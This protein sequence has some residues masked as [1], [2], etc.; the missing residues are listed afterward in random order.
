MDSLTNIFNNA[1]RGG[2]AA[3]VAVVLNTAAATSP[4]SAPPTQ[5]AISVATSPI[6]DH[7]RTTKDLVRESESAFSDLDFRTRIRDAVI[8]DIDKVRKDSG[9]S[10]LAQAAADK[11]TAPTQ[12]PDFISPDDIMRAVRNMSRGNGGNNMK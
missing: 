12:K 8:E 9:L 10:S 11:K 1:A 2:A 7:S 5:Q 4:S 6:P 3:A